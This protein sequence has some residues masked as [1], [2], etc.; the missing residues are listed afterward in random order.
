M[1]QA[2]R[3]YIDSGRAETL[4]NPDDLAVAMSLPFRDDLKGYSHTSIPNAGEANYT[5]QPAGAWT[6]LHIDMEHSFLSPQ[7]GSKAWIAFPR[8]RLNEQI[9]YEMHSTT[10][11]H[12]FLCRRALA[13]MEDGR[14]CISE[15]GDLVFVPVEWFHTVITLEPSIWVGTWLIGNGYQML[16]ALYVSMVATR[17]RHYGMNDEQCDGWTEN[18]KGK[19]S[20]ATKTL[21]EDLHHF[22]HPEMINH[23]I[24]VRSFERIWK[25]GRF[26]ERA[27]FLKIASAKGWVSLA[28]RLRE[29]FAEIA[30]GLHKG[31]MIWSKGCFVFRLSECRRNVGEINYGAHETFP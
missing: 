20:V 28:E 17:V 2:T 6:D 25:F 26:R 10:S 14:C 27:L 8:T 4:P 29:T 12:T 16:G 5:I 19:F 11:D 7:D 18:E 31:S 15:K 9:F 13:E 22:D 3:C 24:V 1:A 23:D 21:Y 30:A